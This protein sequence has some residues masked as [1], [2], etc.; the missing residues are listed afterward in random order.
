MTQQQAVRILYLDR[1]HNVITEAPE[2]TPEDIPAA[3]LDISCRLL[4]ECVKRYF[5]LPGVKEKYEVWKKE[6]HDRN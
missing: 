3:N 6:Q 1:D 2:F 4:A 5:E